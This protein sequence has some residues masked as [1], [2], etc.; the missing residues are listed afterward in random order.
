MSRL[1]NYNHYV[2]VTDDSGINLQKTQDCWEIVYESE[3]LL[4]A[5]DCSRQLK[6]PDFIRFVHDQRGDKVNY[7]TDWVGDCESPDFRTLEHEL[8]RPIIKPATVVKKQWFINTLDRGTGL[9]SEVQSTGSPFCQDFTVYELCAVYPID[10]KKSKIVCSYTIH[11]LKMNNKLIKSKIIK[12]IDSSEK[13]LAADI[14]A[15][16]K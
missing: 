4:S 3:T 14:C 12:E 6:H 15:A 5:D 11:W 13:L 7:I 1:R 9:F 2:I 16:L 10:E 8:I